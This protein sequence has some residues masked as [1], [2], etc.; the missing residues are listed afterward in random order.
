MPLCFL[1]KVMYLW[2]AS[3]QKTFLSRVEAF[4]ARASAKIHHENAETEVKSKTGGGL[5]D[6]A[7]VCSFLSFVLTH[8][9][10]L[11][12]CLTSSVL[13][14]LLAGGGGL[15]A[16]VYASHVAPT[17]GVPFKFDAN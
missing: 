17:A 4:P 13:I 16:A 6:G 15:T 1:V 7:E 2:V 8:R 5:M 10:Y 14:S 3:L 9:D 11:F 12:S